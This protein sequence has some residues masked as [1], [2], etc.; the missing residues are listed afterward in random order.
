MLTEACLLA[1][2]GGECGLD[3]FMLLRLFVP[4]GSDGDGSGCGSGSGC[5]E[6]STIEAGWN[7]TAG[8]MTSDSKVEDIECQILN[9][10]S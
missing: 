2:G 9:I 6:G 8:S 7:S 4:L 1:E 10:C 5:V 3:V